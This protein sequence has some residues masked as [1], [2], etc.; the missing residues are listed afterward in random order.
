GGL[1][2][3]SEAVR[4]IGIA[5]D[6]GTRVIAPND[7][8]DTCEEHWEEDVMSACR[9]HTSNQT[10]TSKRIKKKLMI[11]FVRSGAITP[12]PIAGY[13]KPAGA[14]T[15]ADWKTDDSATPLIQ[16]G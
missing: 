6:H 12:R 11:R 16:Q 7:C 5:V 3:G 14:K 1:V 8:V 10:H 9:D 13:F 15:C 4:L 2:R